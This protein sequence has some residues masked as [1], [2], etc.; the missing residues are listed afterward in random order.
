MAPSARSGE[1]GD[2]LSLAAGV[3]GGLKIERALKDLEVENSRL[4][5]A[6]SDLTLDKLNL[7]GGSKGNF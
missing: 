2:F 5:K 7:T 6:V 1:R 3:F 4:P